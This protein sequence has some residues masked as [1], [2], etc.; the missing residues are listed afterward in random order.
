MLIPIRPVAAVAVA[1]DVV[2]GGALL[3]ADSAQGNWPAWIA[4]PANLTAVILLLWGWWRGELIRLPVH[5]AAIA[6]ERDHADERVAAAEALAE[7]R[8]VGMQRELDAHRARLEAVV[9]DRDAWRTA[10]SAEVDAR[11]QSEQAA[12]KLVEAQG[13]TVRLLTA[14]ERIMGGHGPTSGTSG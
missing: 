12:A 13:V 3:L 2:A 6:S 10:H 8:L 7:E 14:L 1:V 11:R 5:A 4:L 9:A